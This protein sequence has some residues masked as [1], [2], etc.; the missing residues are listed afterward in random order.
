MGRTPGCSGGS[1]SRY[2]TT[3]SRRPE[4]ALS[5]R[6]LAD[7]HL[8]HPAAL[9]AFDDLPMRQR[10]RDAIADLWP[11]AGRASPRRLLG[12]AKEFREERGIAGFAIGAQHQVM[13]IRHPLRRIRQQTPEQRLIA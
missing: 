6:L 10:A 9:T 2:C 7:R 8:N 3:G 13:P 5:D 4:A 11:A 1:V 12:H